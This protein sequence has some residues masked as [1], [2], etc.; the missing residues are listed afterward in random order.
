MI[1]VQTFATIWWLHEPSIR[2]AIITITIQWILVILFVDIGFGV[3]T[4]P[5]G[6]YYAT[7]MPV[8]CCLIMYTCYPMLIFY[9]ASTGAGLVRI[10]GKKELPAST[11]GC[12]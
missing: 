5:P 1:A 12:G 3:H 8:C 10:S 2:A 7:P 4:H 9:L 11:S 6:K